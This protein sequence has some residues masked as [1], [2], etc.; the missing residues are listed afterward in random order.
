[1]KTFVTVIAEHD[2]EAGCRPLSIKWHDGR[3]FEIDRVLDARKAASLKSGGIG[4][5]YTV[6]IRDN[7]YYLFDED[8]R[9][10][11]ERI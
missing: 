7:K 1:M 4:M 11:V 5:R 3:T 8:G 6:R 2:P 9:W 10:F